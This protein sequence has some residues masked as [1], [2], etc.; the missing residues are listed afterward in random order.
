LRKWR[1]GRYPDLTGEAKNFGKR[2]FN[3]AITAYKP[4]DNRPGG[5]AD[6]TDAFPGLPAG[7]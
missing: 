1:Q 7:P 5:L 2:I 6:S 4:A 3:F